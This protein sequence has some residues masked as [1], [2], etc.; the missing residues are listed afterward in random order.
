[1][2]INEISGITSTSPKTPEQLRIVTLKRNKDLASKNLQVEKDRQKLAK[3]KST[4][5]NLA[6]KKT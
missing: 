1:M 5:S 4:I 3:A 2:T 6:L